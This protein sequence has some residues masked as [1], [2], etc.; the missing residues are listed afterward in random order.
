[1]VK[2]FRVSAAQKRIIRAAARDGETIYSIAKRFKRSTSTIFGIVHSIQKSRATVV[3]RV[4]ARK[5]REVLDKELDK[6]DMTREV[7]REYLQLAF[8]RKIKKKVT[9]ASFRRL[10]KLADIKA[11]S[12]KSKIDLTEKDLAEGL[13]F[14]NKYVNK[15]E[16]FWLNS[17][18][19]YIDNKAFAICPTQKT[20]R[21]Q[22][23]RSPR[24]VYRYRG[25]RCRRTLRKPS[26]GMRSST[27]MKHLHL[28]V[29][30]SKHGVLFCREVNGTWNAQESVQM[31]R[32]LAPIVRNA[33][34]F[35]AN[36]RIHVLEDNDPSGYKSHD[37]VQAKS[38]L[39]IA[40]FTIPA[41][42]PDLSILDYSIWDNVV[43]RLNEENRTL[44]RRNDFKETRDEYVE[45]VK[46]I[47][48]STDVEFVRN[49]IKNMKKRCSLL[50]QRGG[51][52]V[53]K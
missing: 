1:M 25:Q 9:L 35:N 39:N 40:P 10:L 8:E 42:R 22:L 45:R 15:S 34:G 18:H 46:R 11:Q 32:E 53:D 44:L 41:R 31:Y 6:I 23:R 16:S 48:M 20:K 5:L 2:Y 36:K 24:F 13:A 4:N 17:V 33:H 29:A 19:A 12:P 49:S 43:T 27:G 3:T 37:A 28:T 47:V 7:T 30:V 21:S 38:D 14:G 26:K 50:V 52:N 51:D